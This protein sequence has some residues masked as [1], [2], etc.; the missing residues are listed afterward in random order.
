[1]L[2]TIRP[3]PTDKGEKNGLLLRVSCSVSEGLLTEK[4]FKRKYGSKSLMVI[5][6]QN[7]LKLHINWHI[8]RI[9]RQV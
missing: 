5:L 1:M 4:N 6:Y 2:L 9:F 7:S 3:S 8:E